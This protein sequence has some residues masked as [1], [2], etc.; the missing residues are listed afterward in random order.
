MLTNIYNMEQMAH[1]IPQDRLREATHQMR[2]AEALQKL[3]PESKPEAQT[4]RLP[5]IAPVRNRSA[6]RILQLLRG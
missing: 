4:S 3:I 6:A 2:V 5:E 1:D